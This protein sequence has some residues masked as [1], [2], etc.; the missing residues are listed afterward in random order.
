MAHKLSLYKNLIIRLLNIFNQTN[1]GIIRNCIPTM[2]IQIKAANIENL[3]KLNFCWFEYS[4][5]IYF[6]QTCFCFKFN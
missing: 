6:S 3:V 4:C 5:L 1:I 2:Q